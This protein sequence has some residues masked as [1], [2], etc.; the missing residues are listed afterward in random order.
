MEKVLLPQGQILAPEE[1]ETQ[2]G[3]RLT[4][5]TR[6]VQFLMLFKLFLLCFHMLILIEMLLSEAVQSKLTYG[7]M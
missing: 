4:L 6:R 2:R 7:I 5:L 3:S 1:P